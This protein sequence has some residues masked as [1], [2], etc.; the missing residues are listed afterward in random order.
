MLA[1]TNTETKRLEFIKPYFSFRG[2]FN[3]TCR[4]G[5]KW[6]DALKGEKEVLLTGYEDHHVIRAEVVTISYKP[7][8]RLST[9]DVASHQYAR[10]SRSLERLMRECYSLKFDPETAFV[11]LVGF[12]I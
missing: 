12:D 8:Y 9:M 10:D 5:K 6:F 3:T 4:L 1:S 2:G 11:T 7:F